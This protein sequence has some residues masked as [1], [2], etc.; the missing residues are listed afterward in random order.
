MLLPVVVFLEVDGVLNNSG[1][2][3]ALGSSSV[4]PLDERLLARFRALLRRTGARVVLSCGWRLDVE[5]RRAL[6]VACT[7]AGIRRNVFVGETP[8]IRRRST[9]VVEVRVA[10]IQ[11]WLAENRVVRG[12]ERW[13][14]LSKIDLHRA[15]PDAGKRIV[16]VCGMVGLQD[17]DVRLAMNVLLGVHCVPVAAAVATAEAATAHCDDLSTRAD[18]KSYCSVVNRGYDDKS[19]DVPPKALI[20]D[21]DGTLIDSLHRSELEALL[22]S[23][24]GGTR[25]P[26]PAIQDADGDCVFPRP[27]LDEFLDFC[28]LRFAAVGIWTAASRDWADIVVRGVLGAHRPW[29]FVWTAARCVPRRSFGIGN[30]GGDIAVK[31]LRKLWRSAARR[32]Q[33]FTRRSAVII[34]D[35]SANCMRNHGNALLVSSF[36]VADSWDSQTG[37]FADDT[38]LRL[39]AHMEVAV[40]PVADVRRSL[41]RSGYE[42]VHQTEEQADDSEGSEPF[43]CVACDGSGLL[44]REPCPLCEGGGAISGGASSRSQKSG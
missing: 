44:L 7:A 21:M 16:R 5:A 6:E 11:K 34:E 29:S 40:L 28:F 37:K 2:V 26:C 25:P 18:D 30:D 41:Y 8:E 39:M 33:G 12:V 1:T 15:W 32:M 13:A 23:G 35:T 42:V 19:D 9:C 24:P 17:R 4:P 14:T 10:E 3:A 36:S 20:L 22:L 43:V 27:Y 38:L 31:P